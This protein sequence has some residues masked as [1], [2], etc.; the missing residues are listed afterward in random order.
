MVVVIQAYGYKSLLNY[1]YR[2]FFLHFPLC[3]IIGYEDSIP[4]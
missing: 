1:T 3:F 2:I 4:E